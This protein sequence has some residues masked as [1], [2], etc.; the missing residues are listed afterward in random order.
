LKKIWFFNFTDPIP[1]N[2]SNF[3]RRH[4]S[5]VN[6]LAL[7][8]NHITWVTNNFSHT[9]KKHLHADACHT[10]L[11]I[12]KLNSL[13]YKKNISFRRIFHNI[14]LSF[15]VFTLIIKT[16][17]RL[18]PEIILIS[19]PPIET[20]FILSILS[21]IYRIKLLIDVRDLHPEVFHDL[22]KSV[23]TR[24]LMHV[25][26]MPYRLMVLST[27]RL[28]DS[29][30][31]TSPDFSH[32]LKKKYRLNVLPKSFYHWYKDDGINEKDLNKFFFTAHIRNYISSVNDP[33][34]FSYCGSLSKR[35]DFLNFIEVFKSI[36]DRSKILVLCGSG[37]QFDTLKK[38]ASSSKNIFVSSQVSREEVSAI[39]KISDYGLLPYP[40]DIDFQLAP[41]TKLSEIL[42]HNL[43]VICSEDTYI[44]KNL[45]NKI[46]GEYYK[47]ND[48]SSLRR[49]IIKSSKTDPIDP[50]NKEYWKK[51]FNY[52]ISS[53]MSEEILL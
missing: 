45:S 5:L 32:Y 10:K 13:G 39:Y 25:V 51:N 43:K 19:F 9:Q 36:N 40:P 14:L 38:K 33:V 35:M 34:V 16:P 2:N 6:N 52:S 48:F 28:S 26:L 47:F 12:L 53:A 21:R 7:K 42:F 41:P 29:I 20:S 4:E 1:S 23:F 17:K 3:S 49:S 15:S 22:F 46:I 37:D 50:I 11:K 24:A 18:K 8:G 31:T 30:F 27:L 44:H